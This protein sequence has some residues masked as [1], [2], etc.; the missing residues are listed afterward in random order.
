MAGRPFTKAENQH[1]LKTVRLTILVDPGLLAS[2]TASAV[3]RGMN[4]SQYVR[5][6]II[7][8]AAKAA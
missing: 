4:V 8:Y 6:A 5:E 3:K 1:T 2:I 7:S